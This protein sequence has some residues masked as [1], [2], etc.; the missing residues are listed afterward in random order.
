MTP[1]EP[2]IYHANS[3]LKRLG[4]LLVRAPLK[5]GQG[6]LLTPCASIHTAFMRYTIDVVFL[7]RFGRIIKIVLRVKPWRMAAC[8]E[9]HQTL[10][11]ISGEAERMQLAPGQI[12]SLPSKSTT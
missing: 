12:L 7:D 5:P 9:A 4:G 10:E 8:G 2:S 1:S 6:L 3:F 11:L